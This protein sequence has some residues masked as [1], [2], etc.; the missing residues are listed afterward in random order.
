MIF[1]T[2]WDDFPKLFFYD[3]DH[4]YASGLDPTY[5]L[6]ANPELSKLYENITLGREEN[7][8]ELI[9]NR[10]GARH[11]FTDNEEIHEELQNKLIESG[12]F[13]IAY[14]DDF[15]TVLRM[16]DQRH[17][18]LKETDNAPGSSEEEKAEEPATE[19]G[20]EAPAL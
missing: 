10:F 17:E 5:L 15:C 14:H 6:E 20:I 19:E 3:S 18:N 8:A 7:A 13:E 9:R 11:V 1:N 16:F 4:N 12:W 2:D